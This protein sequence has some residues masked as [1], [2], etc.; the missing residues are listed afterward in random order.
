M[1]KLIPAICMTLIAAF[2]LASSTFAWFS[3]NKQVTATGMQVTAK[4]DSV[5]LLISQEKTTASEIQ[6]EGQITQAITV[7]KPQVYPSAHKTLTKTSDAT[8][9]GN[10]YYKVADAPGA[11][12]STGV[13]NALTTFEN[14]VIRQTLYITLAAGS[15]NAANLKVSAAIT[16][17][18]TATGSSKTL[19]PVKVVVTT[20]DA[21]VEL[22]S[23]HLSSDVVLAA[24]LTATTVITVDVFIYYDGNNES[25]YT[26]NVTNLD[27]AKIDLTFTV[28]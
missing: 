22:D 13:E 1:K 24:T 15:N 4:S 17:N 26:N 2:M 14:Y 5:Y 19:E 9:V 27:G 23:A 18:G 10:W 12:A 25:V 28:A 21:Y 16:S 6:T 11:S 20:G 8:T 7:A 3:M